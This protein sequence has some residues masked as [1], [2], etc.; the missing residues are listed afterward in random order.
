[1]A[2]HRVAPVGNILSAR[3]ERGKGFGGCHVADADDKA[4]VS[5]QIKQLEDYLGKKLF[6]RRNN[7]L[8]LTDAGD[9]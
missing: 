6:A 8:T 4:A 3:V 9:N 1:M 2:P 7:K 5:H